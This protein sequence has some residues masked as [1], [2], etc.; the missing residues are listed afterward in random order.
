MN[1]TGPDPAGKSFAQLL[2]HRVADLGDWRGELL[3]SIR[4]LIK[5]ADPDVVEEWKWNIP[6]WSHGGLITTGETY[7]ASV[8]LTFARGASL[9][10]PAR[11][12]TSSLEGNVRR[13]IDLREGEPLNEKAFKA[14]VRAAVEQN[15]AAA[16][17]KK[18]KPKAKAPRAKKK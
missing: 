10:D 12:F 15:L 17:A 8:K 2:R 16:D 18:S 3:L 1:H 13:A 4:A 7:Q 11:L 6:V 9:K 14:L 5:E